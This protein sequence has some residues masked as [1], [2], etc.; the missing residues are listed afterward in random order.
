MESVI[1]LW[2]EMT[3][4]G[5]FY[6]AS[7]LFLFLWILG[8]SSL[9]FPSDLSVF[10]PFLSVVAIMLCYIFG[11]SVHIISQRIISLFKRKDKIDAISDRGFLE[12]I[13]ERTR[14]HIEGI[15]NALVLLRL[16]V[17][18]VVVLGVSLVLWI[19]NTA[20]KEYCPKI[21]WA[22]MLLSVFFAFAH[23]SFRRS[24]CELKREMQKLRADWQ[25]TAPS[26]GGG[27]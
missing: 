3:I 20:F 22:C 13:P 10:G 25:R 2:V 5:S 23:C 17:L 27:S 14:R 8:V 6:V 18:G 24:F 7:A 4:A 12:S 19:R 9:Q 16:S 1:K 21:V 11:L 26:T 15:Y